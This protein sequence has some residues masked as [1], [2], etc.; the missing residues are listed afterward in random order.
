[1]IVVPPGSEITSGAVTSGVVSVI[2]IAIES[3]IAKA[4]R[5]ELKPCIEFSVL[6]YCLLIF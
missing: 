5:I 1:V 3:T 6:T 4:S 2:E